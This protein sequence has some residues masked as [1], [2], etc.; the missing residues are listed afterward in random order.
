[1]FDIETDPGKCRDLAGQPKYENPLTVW[2]GRMIEELA[3]RTGDGLSDGARLIPG[4]SLPAVRPGVQA[5]P[6]RTSSRQA[7]DRN[8]A[9]NRP[10]MRACRKPNPAASYLDI[11][12]PG[13]RKSGKK[14]K[15]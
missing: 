8:G 10:S 1:M 13:K 2:R 7:P 5:V 6:Q 4:T 15:V 9:K 14:A 3:P 11:R 12:R